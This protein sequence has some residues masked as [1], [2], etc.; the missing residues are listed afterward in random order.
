MDTIVHHNK[1]SDFTLSWGHELCIYRIN[2]YLIFQPSNP[3]P[4]MAY[5]FAVIYKDCQFRGG[6]ICMSVGVCPGDSQV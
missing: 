6:L 1:N 5:P 4:N 2:I 3:E